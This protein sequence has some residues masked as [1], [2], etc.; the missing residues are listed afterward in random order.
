[1]APEDLLIIKGE[2]ASSIVSLNGIIS[3]LS[4]I[5]V[6]Y[7]D[8]DMSDMPGGKAEINELIAMATEL[9]SQI[10]LILVPAGECTVDSDCVAAPPVCTDTDLD[11]YCLETEDCDD[12][13]AGINPGV[14]LDVCNGVDDNCDGSIDDND[15]FTLD[16]ENSSCNDDDNNCG[17]F[18][19]A[20]PI[21]EV[22][23][24][25][26]CGIYTCEDSDN[27]TDKALKGT[28]TMYFEDGT[29]HQSLP[30]NCINGQLRE[31]TCEDNGKIKQTF[32]DC[33]VGTTCQDGACVTPVIPAD[34]SEVNI[35]LLA[36][37]GIKLAQDVTTL[38]S[39][40]SY[41]VR[42]IIRPA[43]ALTAHLVI[44]TI[45]YGASQKSY[46][47]DTKDA[48]IAGGTE[49]VEFVHQ[50]TATTEQIKISAYVWG[51]WPGVDDP[52]NELL[53]PG[54]ISYGVE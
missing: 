6:N 4:A 24:Y 23:Y 14:F 11:G 15:A 40:E 35:E 43:S 33:A 49:I 2:L 8:C 21:D 41:T 27:G 25:K 29:Q 37:T 54:E 44:V 46:F 48:L 51:G 3:S 38:S 34:D 10:N 17:Y 12:T 19:N 50:P 22:C 31:T 32:Y 45:D 30:D 47:V 1:M 53:T 39:A 42:V 28:A 26:V 18:G 16:L 5:E 20:C 7:V 13:N 52:F 36:S 9:I